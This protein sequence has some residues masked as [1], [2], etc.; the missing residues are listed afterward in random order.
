MV[1]YRNIPQKC[2][3][4]N[5]MEATSHSAGDEVIDNESFARYSEKS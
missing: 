1:S 2:W 4:L 5:Q 3:Q